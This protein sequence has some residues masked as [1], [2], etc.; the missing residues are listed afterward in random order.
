MKCEICNKADAMQ[1]VFVKDDKSGEER[2][3]YVCDK[4]ARRE[5][6]KNSKRRSS[7]RAEDRQSRRSQQNEADEIEIVE[8]SEAIENASSHLFQLLDSI[9]QSIQN[10]IELNSGILGSPGDSETSGKKPRRK[11]REPK[12]VE[13]TLDKAKV[14]KAFLLRHSLHLEGLYLIGELEATIRSAVALDLELR[15][16]SRSTVREAA[17]LFK[18]MYPA[19]NK[20]AAERFLEAVIHQEQNARERLMGEMSL[21]FMDTI[22]R[23]LAILKNCRLLGASELLDLLSCLRLASLAGVLDGISLKKINSMMEGIDFSE[24]NEDIPIEE[25][26]DFDNKRANG[27]NDL[28][29]GVF[30]KE[31]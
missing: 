17:H 3:L 23:S 1:A 5:T 24:D 16:D 6:I 19:K 21:L 14:D 10:N 30:V 13:L 9:T 15:S 2:E 22:C 20:A 11:K 8:G 29:E 26:E 27:I 12:L 31:F 18:I 28:F 25:R 7:V 4:C